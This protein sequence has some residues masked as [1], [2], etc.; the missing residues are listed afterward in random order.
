V[1]TNEQIVGRAAAFIGS[2][3][4]AVHTILIPNELAGW[5]FRDD[6]DLL[7]GIAHASRAVD[8]ATETHAL[9]NRD[10][11]DNS[12][13]HAEVIAIYDWCWGSDPQWLTAQAEDQRCYSHDHGHYFPGG[14]NWKADE[15]IRRLDTANPYPYMGAPFERTLLDE[16]SGRLEGVT[17]SSLVA[18]LSS[19][20]TSWPVSDEELETIGYFLE[21]RAPNVARRL[22]ERSEGQ[23]A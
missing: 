5:K 23:N 9:E 22:R 21:C 7:P 3:A 15:L 17:H 1:C 2:L 12:R 11:D 18:L 13:H 6:R 4:P 20:P 8:S 14:P 16:I 10:K 19:I